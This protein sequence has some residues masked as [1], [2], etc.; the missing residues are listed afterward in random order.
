M[1]EISDKVKKIMESNIIIDS[2]SHGPILWTEDFINA[3]NKMLALNVNPFKIG[4]W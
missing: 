2:L 4:Q 1:K 3:S